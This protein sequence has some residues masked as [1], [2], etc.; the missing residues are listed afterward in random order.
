M[1]NSLTS[2]KKFTSSDDDYKVTTPA[3]FYL[4]KILLHDNEVKKTYK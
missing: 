1:T 3:G 4:E 2:I